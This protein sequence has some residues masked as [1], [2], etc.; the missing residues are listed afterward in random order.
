MLTKMILST[1]SAAFVAIAAAGFIAAPVSVDFAN[2][3]FQLTENVALAKRN[4][5]R[6]DDDR[7]D[8]RHY[9]HERHDDCHGYEH[10]HRSD[11]LHKSG[12]DRRHSGDDCVNKVSDS[13]YR[14]SDDG[15]PDQGPG[16]R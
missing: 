11:H 16:D 14:N 6:D 12:D 2:G 15:T 13:V 10:E 9:S 4:R 3:A 8:Y 5:E 1:T 7:R